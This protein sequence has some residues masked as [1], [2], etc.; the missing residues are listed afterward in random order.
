M[1]KFFVIGPFCTPYSILL[2]IDFWEGSF[3]VLSTKKTVLQI[4]E[5]DFWFFKKSVSKV[6]NVQNLQWLS[7]K[8]VPVSQTEDYFENH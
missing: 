3:V 5:K 8:N 7:H 1:E 2:N 6:Q 4:F